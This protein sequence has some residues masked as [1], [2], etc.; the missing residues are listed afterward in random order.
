M[1][2]SKQSKIGKKIMLFD[3]IEDRTTPIGNGCHII[4]PASWT[5]KKVLVL[6]M[7]R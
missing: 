6:K 7:D 4:L 5:G 1:A 3:A 2:K